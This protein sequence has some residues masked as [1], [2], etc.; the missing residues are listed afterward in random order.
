MKDIDSR[1]ILFGF[2]VNANG[3]IEEI[4]SL[5][6]ASD[7]PLPFNSVIQELRIVDLPITQFV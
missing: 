1:Q 6:D 2:L 4:K 5:I 7:F 3:F